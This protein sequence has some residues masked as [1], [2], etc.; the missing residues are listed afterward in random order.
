MLGQV[1]PA[2]E[3]KL[4][5]DDVRAK[6]AAALAKT[7]LPAAERSEQIA[8]FAAHWQ[9]VNATDAA[10]DLIDNTILKPALVAIDKQFTDQPAVAAT[11]RQVLAN[12]Y[13]G[14]GLYDAALPLQRTALATR[15]RVLGDDNRYTLESVIDLG[16]LLRLQGKLVESERYDREALQNTRRVLGEDNP[17]TL[18]AINN[19][20]AVL[21]EEGRQDE[22]EP[23]MREALAIRRRLLGEKD[24]DTLAS[25]VNMGVLL[26][27]QYKLGE[28]EPYIR[29]AVE[30]MR[31]V[32]GENSPLTLFAVGNLGFLLE[33]EGK[34]AEAERYDRDVLAK[35]RIALGD[36]HPDT[37][38]STSNMGSLLVAQH[39]YA[40]AEKLLSPAEAATRRT[41]T[42]TNAYRVGMLLMHLG[43]ARA[44]LAQY[45]AAE[46]NLLEAQVVFDRNHAFTLR[47]MR[48]RECTQAI[49]DLYNAWNK[50]QPGKSYDLKSAEWRRKLDALRSPVPATVAH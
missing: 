27:K 24:P 3:G 38:I 50:A 8:L 17:D 15:R 6:F 26:E 16:N 12:R 44:G 1:D 2:Q 33:A 4:L 42:G 46:A 18:D 34:L 20:G 30:K 28:A 22:E 10:R 23:Y 13:V 47:D 32:L 36:E 45:S 41:F 39:K 11:L 31:A 37:L 19:M 7:D 9:R 35:R 49:V 25:I 40:E 48:V 29:E 14:M 21:D 43:R 5:S